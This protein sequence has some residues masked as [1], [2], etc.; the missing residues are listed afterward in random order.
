MFWQVLKIILMHTQA[1]KLE[2]KKSEVKV[3][4]KIEKKKS[5]VKIEKKLETP[6]EVISELAYIAPIIANNYKVVD[7]IHLV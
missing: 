4:A 6:K 5:E 7:R 2:K 3:E 1:I